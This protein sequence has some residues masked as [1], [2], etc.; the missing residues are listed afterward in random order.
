MSS[1]LGGE[2]RATEREFDLTAN[3]MERE[4]LQALE[5][6][7]A[8]WSAL[9]NMA[10]CRG[11]QNRVDEAIEYTKRAITAAPNEAEPHCMLG[12]ILL[13][14]DDE[15][16]TAFYHLT[17]AVRIRPDF[18]KAHIGIGLA[19]KRRGQPARAEQAFATAHEIFPEDPL[20]LFNLGVLAA[21]QGKIKR[22]VEM[23]QK[24]LRVAPRFKPASDALANIEGRRRK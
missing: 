20:A 14:R 21:E 6:N 12:Y 10:K 4:A 8:D 16:G 11:Y 24:T 1:Y 9:L 15:L 5:K 23:F 18:V 7:P 22:A 3:E 13:N 17:E 2:F 19:W